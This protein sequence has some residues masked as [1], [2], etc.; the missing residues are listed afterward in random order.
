MICVTGDEVTELTQND[1]L[2]CNEESNST[3]HIYSG[4]FNRI[5][6]IYKILGDNFRSLSH[7]FRSLPFVW[8]RWK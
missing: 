1:I 8:V 5:L 2:Y 7:D 4:I 6:G 3:V